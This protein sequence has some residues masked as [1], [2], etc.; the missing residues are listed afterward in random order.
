MT[1]S[2]VKYGLK[3]SKTLEEADLVLFNTCSVRHT[4]ENK[5]IGKLVSLA[6][7]KRKGTILGVSGCVANHRKDHLLDS[8]PHV[9]FIMGTNNLHAILDII[10]ELISTGKRIIRVDDVFE[11]DL[12]YR[13]AERADN[14]SAF[15][16][17]IRGCNKYC[18]YCIVPYTKGPEV[19][20][21]YNN[22]LDECIDLANRGYKEITLLGENVNGYGKDRDDGILF[23]HLLEKLHEIPGIE[24]IRFMTSHPIDISDEL[25]ESIGALP[26]VCEFVHFCL[27]SGSNRILKKMNRM[28]TRESYQ[29]KVKKI[30]TT[31]KKKHELLR[32]T[33]HPDLFPDWGIGSDFIVGFPTETEEEF[34]QTKTAVKEDNF[35]TAFFFMYSPR[36]GTPST[37]FM[38]NVTKEEKLNRLQQLLDLHE[39]ISLEQRK[40]AI[41][42]VVE[43]L[44]E[45]PSFKEE[46]FVK[47]RT[48]GWWRAILPGTTNLI[49]TIQTIRVLDVKHLT[50]IGEPVTPSC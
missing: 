40:K 14:V 41:G 6:K 21:K 27:Q 22:I 39:Q 44:V 4:A 20:R 26:K 35:T 19:S 29:E 32:Q 16:S 1:G 13:L 15:V 31:L 10:E 28:Y 7:T 34:L 11:H 24:R 5:A 48:R 38:D 30:Q 23:H 42:K 2:L 45:G 18:T 25:I 3:K 8:L 12:D 47:G 36:K 50:L 9:D 37:R 46:N 43:V 17:I 49:G 33:I